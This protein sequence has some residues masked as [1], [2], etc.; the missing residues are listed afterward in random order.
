MKPMEHSAFPS[1]ETLAAFIDGQL[2]EETRK[3]VVAH[4]ADCEDCYGTVMAAGAWGTN[5]GRQVLS[6]TPR[7]FVAQRRRYRI[8]LAAAA[9]IAGLLLYDP[10]SARYR[11]HRDIAAL[12]S[13]ANELPERNTDGRLS[14]DLEHKP[15]K[16]YRGPTTHA[17]DEYKVKSAIALLNQDTRKAATP[18]SQHSLAVAFL[19]EGNY[20]SAIPLLVNVLT[21]ETGVTNVLDAIR[22]CDDA[23]LLA[24]IAAA[25]AE[26]PASEE[27]EGKEDVALEAASR[28]WQL[29][30]NSAQV[31][32][33]RAI[34]LE[35]RE[36]SAAAAAWNDYLAVDTSSSWRQEARA[37]LRRLPG[38][39]SPM[40]LP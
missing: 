17:T 20:Q 27:G 39:S 36:P 12:R 8:G 21:R 10:L 3:Q 7:S 1:D 35:R 28:A 13:A 4:V 11:Q 2:D 38:V 33:N 24:D 16:R 31:A 14:L 5:E 37:R 19:V 22:K 25:Y 34:V 40:R 26:R 15:V 30:R 23:P 32:W 6:V 18:A 9:V 29:N